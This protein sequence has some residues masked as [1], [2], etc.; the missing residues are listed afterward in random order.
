MQRYPVFI[1]ATGE[2]LIRSTRCAEEYPAG[3]RRGSA[4]KRR[5]RPGWIRAAKARRQLS[6]LLPPPRPHLL[7]ALV[8]SIAFAFD[9]GHVGVMQ[10]AVQQGH[11][12]S[13]IG[14]D[15][16]PLFE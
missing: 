16:V 9:H 3:R 13:S 5:T 7:L 12:A 2:P 4:P 1:E 6:P 10:Q 8:N 15:F 11:D 14:K